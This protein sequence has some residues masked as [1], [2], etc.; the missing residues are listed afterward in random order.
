MINARLL[1]TLHYLGLALL[2]LRCVGTPSYLSA[3]VAGGTIQGVIA[4][5]SGA[6][7][8]GAH[9]TIT[10]TATGTTRSAITNSSGSYSVP[11]LQPSQY[12]VAVTAP[13]FSP[14]VANG[15][16]LT[17]GANLTVNFSLKVG[18]STEE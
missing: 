17:V 3:Q 12:S 7:I 18:N 14:E 2:L 9:L 4:D 5:S 1:R 11:N 6:A 8:V 16:T 13:G 15:I 10:E